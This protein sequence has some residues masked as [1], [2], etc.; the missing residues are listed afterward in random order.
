MLVALHLSILLYTSLQSEVDTCTVYD[1]MKTDFSFISKL[2]RGTALG[3][4]DWTTNTS[5]YVPIDCYLKTKKENQLQ[6]KKGKFFS[7]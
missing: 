4:I 6:P 5:T 3:G 7:A 2:R 1:L